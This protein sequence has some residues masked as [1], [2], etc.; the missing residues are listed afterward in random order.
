MQDIIIDR[1]CPLVIDKLE[2][3]IMYNKSYND[4]V[5]VCLPY[6]PCTKV[7]YRQYNYHHLVKC[8]RRQSGF[9]TGGGGNQ[10]FP[11]PKSSFPPKNFEIDKVIIS[12]MKYN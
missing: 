5:C 1:D 10:E 8:P 6:I 11:P 7:V 4:Y 12:A 3:F 2:H 9:H